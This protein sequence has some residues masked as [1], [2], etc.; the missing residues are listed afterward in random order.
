MGSEWFEAASCCF[1]FCRLSI[2][3]SEET[4]ALRHTL[5]RL[6][7][8]LH[9]VAL[10]E[11]VCDK[12]MK[13]LGFE[14]IDAAGLDPESLAVLIDTKHKEALVYQ[15]IHQIIVDS[16]Q[17]KVMNVPP[18]IMT[19]VFQQLAQG[20]Q[21][22]HCAVKIP[23]VP[24]PFPYTQTTTALLIIHWLVTP[25]TMVVWTEWPHGAAIFTF[26]PVFILC[27]LN[28]IASE[29]GEPFGADA[30]DIDLTSIQ[31]DFNE[32]LLLLFAPSTIRSPSLSSWAECDH[33]R[34]VTKSE[35]LRPSLI[36]SCNAAAG[37]SEDLSRKVHP[38]PWRTAKRMAK[39]LRQMQ[40][41]RLGKRADDP[42]KFD[43]WSSAELRPDRQT[44]TVPRNPLT[45]SV[46]TAS[47]CIQKS[48]G[49]SAESPVEVI[50][51]PTGG[52]D[53]KFEPSTPVCCFSPP[54]PSTPVGSDK[55]VASSCP[56]GTSIVPDH[57]CVAA[58]IDESRL[59][60]IGKAD[61]V[62]D[63]MTSVPQSSRV[64][65]PDANA[66]VRE[67]SSVRL[68]PEMRGAEAM[69]RQSL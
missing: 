10:Q 20:M 66:V 2:R 44:E 48:S 30:N 12:Q 19:R 26:I 53:S 57:A 51:L 46:E 7:S 63:S 41:M 16:S 69:P 35:T 4:D 11:L 1:A 61:T 60:N 49:I 52:V 38:H 24:F 37:S 67:V 13:H 14:I 58:V 56:N 28:R 36:R 39:Q 8:A 62:S 32:K 34:L 31:S 42:P 50:V 40:T 3:S 29:I 65:T 17:R 23:Q 21:E 25:F 59:R 64:S 68:P 5:L 55:H 33:A 54:D 43:I 15:W 18:P 22:F 6:F 27:S 45:S 47:V 9:A